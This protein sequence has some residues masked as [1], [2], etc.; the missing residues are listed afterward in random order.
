MEKGTK[1]NSDIPLSKRDTDSYIEKKNCTNAEWSEWND[2][3]PE[4]KDLKVL[5][6]EKVKYTQ[7]HAL[8]AQKAN[9]QNR[10]GQKAS[11]FPPLL[12]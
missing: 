3:R 6:D 4:K 5:L 2:S 1:A 11:D 12:Q 7:T 10:H 8:A 9:M